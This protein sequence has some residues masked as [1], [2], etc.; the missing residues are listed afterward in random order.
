MCLATL[1]QLFS[2]IQNRSTGLPNSQSKACLIFFF[3]FHFT[4]EVSH[5]SDLTLPG[6]HE[7]LSC[8][9]P[10]RTNQSKHHTPELFGESTHGKPSTST[11][12]ASRVPD[13]GKSATTGAR[14]TNSR[15]SASHRPDC[16]FIEDFPIERLPQ[17]PTDLAML[18]DQGFLHCWK[19]GVCLRHPRL[20]LLLY[21]APDPEDT[22]RQLVITE[23]SPC[24]QGRRV[25]SYVVDHIDTLIREWY[26][27]L[28]T[29]DGWRPKVRQLIPC[30]VCERLGLE[31][32]KF[33]FT[34]CQRQSSKSDMITCPKHPRLQVNLHQVA[35]DIMLHDVDADLLLSQD[36][37]TYEDTDSSTLGSGGFGKVKYIDVTVVKRI[38][39]YGLKRDLVQSKRN[40]PILFCKNQY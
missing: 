19:S 1:I 24:P 32:Y 40:S 33:T 30:V 29:T 15:F 38:K 39:T 5:T 21:C 22:D 25:L 8:N 13:P 14:R 37:I 6:D 4:T 16:P 10:C 18:I 26:Q 23:V 31:P 35:P 17:L 2:N 3:W 34:E 11:L 12:S 20:F 36:E 9:T 7:S 28:S 27:E